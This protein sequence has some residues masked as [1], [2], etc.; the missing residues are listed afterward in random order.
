MLHQ[1]VA[2]SIANL[3]TETRTLLWVGLEEA[4]VAHGAIGWAGTLKLWLDILS[5]LFAALETYHALPRRW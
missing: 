4:A 3:Y 5:H 1:G 2:P